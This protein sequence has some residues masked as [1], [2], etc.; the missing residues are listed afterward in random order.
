M[1]LVLQEVICK[2]GNVPLPQS[3]V[4]LPGG[5]PS[6][7]N[8][9]RV[10]PLPNELI[11]APAP[12]DPATPQPTPVNTGKR[13]KPHSSWKA[14]GSHASAAT[15]SQNQPKKKKESKQQQHQRRWAGI[16]QIR[17][18]TTA[19]TSAVPTQSVESRHSPVL[20]E[21]ITV[22]ECTRAGITEDL[23]KEVKECKVDL[24]RI[25]QELLELG[26]F[27][28]E[29]FHE[30]SPS[31]R[32]ESILIPPGMV[33]PQRGNAAA[34]TPEL[35]IHHYQHPLPTRRPRKGNRQSSANRTANKDAKKKSEDGYASSP[36]ST[37]SASLG[38]ERSDAVEKSAKEKAS[39][40]KEHQQQSN[41]Q[42]GKWRKVGSAGSPVVP[43][44]SSCS[45]SSTA[46]VA[47]AG[48]NRN[49][50]SVESDHFVSPQVATSREK[51]AKPRG[52]T[53][54]VATKEADGSANS[55][56][57][58]PAASEIEMLSLYMP[59]SPW[60]TIGSSPIQSD[61]SSNLDMPVVVGSN[62]STEKG[63][64]NHRRTGS[65][66]SLK[67]LEASQTM[68]KTEKANSVEGSPRADTPPQRP[69]PNQPANAPGS[70]QGNGN[71]KSP[72]MNSRTHASPEQGKISNSEV[73]APT[74]DKS[75]T[76]PPSELKRHVVV[77]DGTPVCMPSLVSKP[78]FSVAHLASMH[79]PNDQY[80]HQ[81]QQ[82]QHPTVG[83]MMRDHRSATPIDHYSPTTST[84]VQAGAHPHGHQAGTVDLSSLR[85][86][87][88]SSSSSLR[89]LK[90][91][92]SVDDNASTHSLPS[93][94]P[95]HSRVS[96]VRQTSSPLTQQAL[97][98]VPFLGGV[99]VGDAKLANSI[100]VGNDSSKL[101]MNPPVGMSWLPGTS[102]AVSQLAGQSGLLNPSASVASA[103]N[104]SGLPCYPFSF[105]PPG[106]GSWLPAAA[107][108]MLGAPGLRPMLSLDPSS[109][110]YKPVFN[111][112]LSYRYPL[113][114]SQSLKGFPPSSSPHVSQTPPGIGMA[115]IKPSSS[116]SSS[117]QQSG[118]YPLAPSP[119]ISAFHTVSGEPGAKT[120]QANGATPPLLCL[121][122]GQVQNFPGMIPPSVLLAGSHDDNTS[123]TNKGPETSLP[124][125]LSAINWVQNPSALMSSGTNLVPY[126]MGQAQ[127]G[128]P[129]APGGQQAVN[130][131]SNAHL[132]GIPPQ[133]SL[134]GSEGNLAKIG[135]G[136]SSIVSS[137]LQTKDHTMF[138]PH[139][140]QPQRR[141]S[142]ASV[143]MRGELSPSNTP[144]LG[145]GQSG[146]PKKSPYSIKVPQG[147]KWKTSGDQV[148]NS[149]VI[150]PFEYQSAESSQTTGSGVPLMSPSGH[151]MQPGFPGM[152]HSRLPKGRGEMVIGSGGRGS[153]RG[154][155]DKPKL[156][157]H[158]V[159]DDDFKQ[160]VKPDRRRKRWRGKSRDAYLPP[161]NEDSETPLQ[162]VKKVGELSAPLPPFPQSI[163]VEPGTIQS[164]GRNKPNKYSLQEDGNNTTLLKS[165]PGNKLKDGNYALNM[166]ADMSSIQ[167]EEKSNNVLM[168]GSLD[169]N[170]NNSASNNI[171]TPSTAAIASSDA[172]RHLMR[173][174]VTLAAR[175]LLMLGE[176]L[177]QPHTASS[178]QVVSGSKNL[179]LSVENTAA[180]SLLQL[181]G[182]VVP[183]GQKSQKVERT[184][185][186]QS[187]D[188]NVSTGSTRSASFSAA[189]AMIMMGCTKEPAAKKTDMGSS[190]H[191]EV[192][193]TSRLH[194]PVASAN[195]GNAPLVSASGG[196]RS[197]KSSAVRLER[198][199]SISLD[200]EVTD[201]DSEATLTPDSPQ[202]SRQKR[203]PDVIHMSVDSGSKEHVGILL[204]HPSLHIT[205]SHVEL[206]SDD[207]GDERV[208]ELNERQEVET[209]NSDQR[210]VWEDNRSTLFDSKPSAEAAETVEPVAKSSKKLTEG[211]NFTQTAT[212]CSSSIPLAPT[213]LTVAGTFTPPPIASNFSEVQHNASHMVDTEAKSEMKQP[214]F[215]S[216]FGP[217]SESVAQ[218]LPVEIDGKDNYGTPSKINQSD[219]LN[220]LRLPSP[221]FDK[222][223]SSEMPSEEEKG[224]SKISVSA[225]SPEKLS[226]E[227]SEVLLENDVDS[228]VKVQCDDSDKIAE[229]LE[230][231]AMTTIMEDNLEKNSTSVMEKSKQR[232]IKIKRNNTRV[233]PVT[234]P[235]APEVSVSNRYTESSSDA[236]P[237]WAAFAD[238]AQLGS[239]KEETAKDAADSTGKHVGL[240]KPS[241]NDDSSDSSSMTD[242]I[243][244][245]GE[246]SH[247]NKAIE[248]I[249]ENLAQRSPDTVPFNILSDG[250][251]SSPVDGDRHTEHS[252]KA[253][254]S[255]GDG[256]QHKNKP[257][258]KEREKKQENQH[259]NSPGGIENTGANGKVYKALQQSKTSFS[260]SEQFSEVDFRYDRHAD[261]HTA[262]NSDNISTTKRS[263]PYNQN[264]QLPSSNKPNEHFSPLSDD[265]DA[266]NIESLPRPVHRESSHPKC[267]EIE[268]LERKQ[269][270]YQGEY[271]DS[272]ASLVPSPASSTSSSSAKKRHSHHHHHHHHHHRHQDKFSATDLSLSSKCDHHREK[273]LSTSRGSSPA[274]HKKRNHRQHHSSH[275]YRK[276]SREGQ[277]S[278]DVQEGTLKDDHALVGASRLNRE[279]WQESNR[280][281]I[282]S[283]S[284]GGGGKS[285]KRPFV[286]SDEDDVPLDY[287]SGSGSAKPSFKRK[288][289]HSRD[290]KERW[291]D[292]RHG[293]HKH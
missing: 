246:L 89:S 252:L 104:A 33:G 179:S 58:I 53:S 254:R 285:R 85:H 225:R 288:A 275:H 76:G 154:I 63:P 271:C 147:G 26:P 131:L 282:S 219:E 267:I 278:R 188:E 189:E 203:S 37:S 184:L 211:L 217:V 216:T 84:S 229:N 116:G 194:Q 127:L 12:P 137:G 165:V 191:A 130:L 96:G 283:S 162:K 102:A 157:M 19:T 21:A 270:R 98:Q 29:I 181:S 56:N 240:L 207:S 239:G 122:P 2:D 226:N 90:Q 36:M 178:G 114:V 238:A 60:E 158:H 61:H 205:S 195:G 260:H 44:H 163:N 71:W 31:R 124:T 146:P 126:L 144:P 45:V 86:R 213:R 280:S 128:L 15:L 171:P 245:L 209:L 185:L 222:Q 293:P 50:P 223:H 202:C 93:P 47:L 263:Q 170:R 1:L 274:D 25:D 248:T 199:R 190:G 145:M 32:N 42:K 155:N 95:P 11:A 73:R 249:D 224:N 48:S 292:H 208:G 70:V 14:V 16:E 27:A 77:R 94:L 22:Q 279:D 276:H 176:D 20:L 54:N 150:H 8:E 186:E 123:G 230:A 7:S 55:P 177:N 149:L 255:L 88:T 284:G 241:D 214:K 140:P 159:R 24:E 109:A 119:N 148:P 57:M 201:T 235:S 192:F 180:T 68:S 83:H 35:F 196:R 169:G 107:G 67:S 262:S 135:G 40:T 286:S 49:S 13:H 221:S 237:S 173:S 166:L 182:A 200:S 105:L 259:R 23:A 82:Q 269:K 87:R 3:N 51:K 64:S 121:Q 273:S 218:S 183:E 266:E 78:G 287:S 46:G 161:R 253:I 38:D 72:L 69:H 281:V 10:P 81:Q 167:R 168:P 220:D 9:P 233:I 134:H 204:R 101:V 52:N 172:S 138:I 120:S 264:S 215:I 41:V 99:S 30:L 34:S 250:I 97:Q 268:E 106:A 164:G 4:S 74:P 143:E 206:L 156:R 243:L 59:N 62:S 153:P 175:S 117:G 66:V 129:G 160:P 251:D 228:S 80:Y 232:T 187:V 65:D 136:P 277:R 75:A 141:G 234:S 112:L 151:M 133:P 139:R 91:Q 111:P 291:R 125:P 108:G 17:K 261:R 39:A 79:E 289:K 5:L 242:G 118:V 198:P 272:A 132:A 142:S 193:E 115:S 227:G 6:T 210:S 236:L 92:H 113:G 256:R 174:P 197:D 43:P 257:E 231:G 103:I 265:D 100:L 110:G 247:V 212:E 244:S 258:L 290:H 28:K 18:N 152:A